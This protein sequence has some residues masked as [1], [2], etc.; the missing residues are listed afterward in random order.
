MFPFFTPII[1]LLIAITGVDAP[2]G[3][4][5]TIETIKKESAAFSQALQQEDMDKVLGYIDSNTM[6]L[7]E[8]HSALES[9]SEIEAYYSKFFKLSETQKIQKEPFEVLRFGDYFQELGTF[10]HTYQIKDKDWF[11]YEG[12]YMTWW[13][14]TE[15]DGLKILAHVWGGS[16]WYEPE[17]LSFFQVTTKP[18]KPLIPK[19]P[20]EHQITKKI[21]TT[22]KAVKAG[23]FKK[24][25]EGYLEDA[26]YMT[27]YDA[28]FNGKQA[29]TEYFASHYD[30][31]VVRDSLEIHV[32]GLFLWETIH[33]S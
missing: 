25:S 15:N 28:P 9:P 7:P 12:K 4:T 1:S 18:G 13:K 31:K 5:N 22:T 27:Y 2:F 8:Y 16:R 24:L 19:T 14:K 33:C 11:T 29:I 21:N 26:I 10:E 23:D 32:I 6:V 20:L 30:P 17:Q 3:A